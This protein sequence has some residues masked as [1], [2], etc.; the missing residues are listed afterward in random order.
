MM[1]RAMA[2]SSHSR[3]V[4][5][6]E[7]VQIALEHYGAGRLG[8]A[9]N[10]CQQVLAAFKDHF[11]AMHLLGLVAHRAG[12]HGQAV[13]FLSRSVALQPAIAGARVNLGWALRASG[14]PQRAL[15]EAQAAAKLDANFAEAQMLAG[16]VLHEAG[17]LDLAVG[18]WERWA[19]LR[20]E[21]GEA[22]AAL[23]VAYERL[24]RIEEAVHAGARAVKLQPNSPVAHVNYGATLAK[25]GRLSEALDEHR[26][27]TELAP[28]L[29]VAWA[30]RSFDALQLGQLEEAITAARRGIDLN[31]AEVMA[32]QNLAA[33]LQDLGQLDEA[34][35]SYGEATRL[36]EA[37]AA[38]ADQQ[39]PAVAAA[40]RRLAT[41]LRAASLTLL[42]PVY[43]SAEEIDRWRERLVAGV[44]DWKAS[45]RRIDVQHD[46]A[47]TLFALAYHGR[48]DVDVNRAYAS[49]VTPP[50]DRPLSE[51]HDG[52]KI[53]VGFISRFF[54]AHTI[55]RLNIG[56][57]EQFDR[58]EFEVVVFSVGDT[59]DAIS[60]RFREAADRFHVLPPSALQV[61][62]D[63]IAA[64]NLDVLFY[65]DIG[66]DPVTYSLAHSRLA[67]VQC[68][69]W[70]HPVT[71]GIA[72][73]DYF[74]SSTSLEP[75]EGAESCYTE[76]LVKLSS[77]A[78][79]YERP[80]LASPKTRAE[81]GLPED[82]TLYGCLQ[83]LWKFH[84]DF[85]A[86]IG[87]VLRRDPKGQLLIIE[88]LSRTWDERLKER[89]RRTI[90][91]VADRVRF[92]PRRGYDDFL[93]LT[94]AC[95]VMLD[96][97]HFGGGNTTYEALAFG[98]PVVTLPSR[99]LRGRIS[100]ALYDQMGV[101]DCVAKSAEHYVELA[102]SLGA[103]ADRRNAVRQILLE[104]A[105][106]IL[107]NPTGVRELEQF[108][109]GAVL[110]AS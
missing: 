47:P 30:N 42:P 17:R 14:R 109:R 33:A 45:G 11:D 9:A 72:T 87:G 23:A 94:A 43:Q 110:R 36:L 100:T 3:E 46:P 20:P 15:E 105:G 5:P 19:A 93:A 76:K 56:L 13:E 40:D 55:G 74:I 108:F 4:T 16:T 68:A 83:M 10:V 52:G 63:A 31:P 82:A 39:A 97:I 26:R 66:M 37:R 12:H 60:Q 2:E 88:G 29:A 44:N 81:L 101:A 85:D 91:D 92:L 80:K 69:T 84:P 73:V 67:R 75:A 59:A 27:A 22:F 41:Q 34:S 57:V 61:A 71:S 6:D 79:Y 86:V 48:D 8:D 35:A 51:R 7:A 99:F 62:R 89:F 90:P 38:Q 98:V 78:V 70:G 106:A 95:D 1:L 58:A 102:A 53:R 107:E 104:R 103:D 25:L 64:E 24:G 54:H 50:P 65:A 21:S 96:P 28:G 49:L 18:H 77:L 32:H